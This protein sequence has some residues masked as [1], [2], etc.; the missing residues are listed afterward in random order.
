M[1]AGRRVILLVLDGVGI[2]ALPDAAEFGD[3]PTCNSL[4]NT[5]RAVGGLRLPNLGA[6]GLGNIAP[7]PGVPPAVQPAGGYG[8]MA[9]RSRGKDTVIGHW[10]LAGVIS[11]R[12]QP[13]YPHGFPPEVIDPFCRAIGRGVLGNR[14]ASGTAIIQ[15]LGTE[16]LRTGEPIVYTSA[17]SVFQVAAHTDVVPLAELYRWC[18]IARGQ[19]Q[20]AHAVGRVIARPFAGPPGAFV[21][22]P[23]R[24]DWAL[25]PPEQTLL[26]N[27]QAAGLTVAAVGKIEDIFSGRGI[28]LSNHT[29]TNMEAVGAT[30]DFLGQVG[31]GLLFVNLVENDMIYGHRN[32]PRGYA[33]AL[34]AFD[35]RLPDLRAS[36]RSDD[37]LLIVGDHGVDP[38]TPGSDHSREYVPLLVAAERVR[39]VNLGTRATFADAGQTAAALLGV[40]PLAAGE[41]FAAAIAVT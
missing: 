10:E 23:D 36:M 27:V 14:P 16:H 5:A 7:I 21:R 25:P 35:A 28:T 39:V 41:S 18:E 11:P 19:L 29:H 3:P 31:A 40:P 32:D 15:E 30:V 37:V 38:T 13:T 20:G 17:D 6:L 12:P 8:K 26:D 24:R 34:E 1:P 2:G 22:T 4:A 9:E 33:A